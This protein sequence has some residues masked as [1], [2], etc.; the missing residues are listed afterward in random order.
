MGAVYTPMEYQPILNQTLIPFT[1]LASFLFL[2]RR[3]YSMALLGACLIFLG[4]I[5]SV[6]PALIHGQPATSRYRWYSCLI[7]MLSTSPCRAILQDKER[8]TSQGRR[9]VNVWYLC[10]WVSWYQFL[11]SFL[12][13]PFLALPFIGGSST[14]TPLSELPKQFLDG[15]IAG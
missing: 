9:T 15:L 4:A 7:Y 11:V 8:C 3:Y 5:T 2:G 13:I 6:S 14:P 10:F 1:M 12:F